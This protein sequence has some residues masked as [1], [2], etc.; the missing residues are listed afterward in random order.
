MQGELSL[1]RKAVTVPIGTKIFRTASATSFAWS[2]STK[3]TFFPHELSSDTACQCSNTYSFLLVAFTAA[4]FSRATM[5]P[6]AMDS[7]R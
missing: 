6:L 3:F 2:P 4:S 5:R 1:Y 7:M